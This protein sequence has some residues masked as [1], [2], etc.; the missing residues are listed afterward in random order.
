MDIKE[1]KA[2]ADINPDE[3]YPEDEPDVSK[4][5]RFRRRICDV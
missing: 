4:P 1:H 3:Y 5:E 2:A